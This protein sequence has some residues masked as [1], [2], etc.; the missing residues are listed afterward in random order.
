MAKTLR[1]ALTLVSALAMVGCGGEKTSEAGGELTEV[2]KVIQEA[3][4]MDAKDL[5]KKAIEE[6]NGKTMNA[7]GN[8]SRGKKSAPYF[9][10]YLRG[11]TLAEDG[12]TE[13]AST[14]IR[15]EFPNYDPNFKGQINWQQ[16]K[17]NKIFDQIYGDANGGKT[18]SMTLI[19]DGSQIQSRMLDTKILENYVP[20][21]WKGSD[22][23]KEP[24][25][26]LQS[27]NKVFEF[28]NLDT[29]KSYKNVW[30]FVAANEKPNFMGIESEP[31]GRNFLVQLTAP[32]Y[33]AMMKTAYDKLTGD[34][35]TYVDSAIA[36]V[37][38]EDVVNTYGLAG[39]DENVK[40]SLAFDY[41]WMKQY[42][43]QTDD[44][45]ICNNLVSSSAAGQTGLL[46]Y[47]KLRSV[48]ETEGVSKKNV[49]MAA[50][51][52]DYAGIGGYMYKHYMAVIKTSPLPWTSCAF[53][54]FLTTTKDGFKAWG[55]DIGG[56][57]SDENVRQK[58]DHSRDGYNDKNE[59]EF[60]ILNDKGYDWWEQRCVVEDPKYVSSNVML[61]SWL[62][63]LRS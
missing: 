62:G 11:N 37:E 12:K 40:Y 46:V 17:N 58:F 25:L 43:E 22:V 63:G 55:N 57:A 31:V 42:S 16:P 28:N 36:A 10:A 51:Q 50:Y 49:T 14:E 26:A 29:S 32:K 45:P 3:E 7:V 21:E 54:H 38:K 34:K 59:N 35:K 6:L 53:I 19:Q 13:V 60:P 44:A 23:N 39:V 18:L 41:L 61:A 4:K 52:D 20:K 9:L 1:V 33:A 2:Q 8:S 30:D 15:S 24:L 5:Y 27:L 48:K 56:Y 47:S